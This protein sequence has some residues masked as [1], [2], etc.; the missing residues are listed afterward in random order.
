VRLIDPSY[1]DYYDYLFNY[2][3][4]TD[5]VIF[6]RRGS[7]PIEKSDLVKFFCVRDGQYSDTFFH[8][9]T[10]CQ[11]LALRAGQKV[12]FFRLKNPV[13]IQ[14]KNWQLQDRPFQADEYTYDADIEFLNSYWD[15]E[16][17]EDILAL[18]RASYRIQ[19][20][21]DKGWF[22]KAVDPDFS[23]LG[24]KDWK[25]EEIHD[26][27]T[28]EKM[29]PLPILVNSGIPSI[30]PAEELFQ[31]IEQF[32]SATYNE[33]KIESIGIT[34]KEKIVNHGF[35]PKTGFRPNIK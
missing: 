31:G 8:N 24:L 16:Q 25:F 30:V 10:K 15:Y 32:I 26:P 23:S 2:G 22:R 7:T 28:K 29:W 17:R 19:W 13:R 35:D 4:K 27:Y 12:F 6:D 14:K 9:E 18:G 1:K 33:E 11:S 21:R 20:V 34:D 5:K 3:D